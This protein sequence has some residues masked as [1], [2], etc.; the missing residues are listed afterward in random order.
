MVHRP[1]IEPGPPAWQASILPLNHRCHRTTTGDSSQAIGRIF[2]PVGFLGPFVL[3]VKLLMQE[4]WKLS[5][6]WDDDLPE[7]LS[8]ALNRWCNEVPGLGELRIPRCFFSN[9]F[10]MWA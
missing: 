6:D 8:L 2:D 4:I 1:G 5:L 3:R 10:N 7:C 9:M